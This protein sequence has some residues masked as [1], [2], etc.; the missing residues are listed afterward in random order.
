VRWP[1]NWALAAA[2][3]A[4]FFAAQAIATHDEEQDV[5]DDAEHAQLL[6]EADARIARTAQ[7]VCL[8]EMG[9][10]YQP[11]WTADGQLQCKPTGVLVAKGGSQ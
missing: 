3:A 1:S 7:A 8:S 6:A 2:G 10:A 9:P 11:G 5:A 4:I